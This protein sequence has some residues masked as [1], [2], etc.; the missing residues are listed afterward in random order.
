MGYAA[1]LK[2]LP[3]ALAELLLRLHKVMIARQAGQ[4]VNPEI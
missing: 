4:A 2:G 1:A 3:D